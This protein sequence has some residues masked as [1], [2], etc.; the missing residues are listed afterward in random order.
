[1]YVSIN[2]ILVSLIAVSC[3]AAIESPQEDR[4]GPG[5]HILEGHKA[6]QAQ[7]MSLDFLQEQES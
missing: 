2:L 1:M 6:V 5:K 7:K 3:W 4:M